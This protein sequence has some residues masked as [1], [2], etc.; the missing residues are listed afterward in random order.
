MI[1]GNISRAPAYKMD[2]FARIP[3]FQALT[4]LEMYRDVP[5]E[6]D[7]A[8]RAQAGDLMSLYDVRY[9]ITTP[10]IPG[11]YPYQDTWQRTEE[12]ALDVLPLE[13][14]AF[15]E[16][17]GYRAYR[18]VQPPIPFPFRLD[19]G[20]RGDRAVPGPGLGH[21]AGRAAIRRHRHVDLGQRPPT[22]SA[23][24]RPA[25]VRLRPVRSRPSATRAR[26]P[27]PSR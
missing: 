17:D 22:L 6:V 13:K 14:P 12:Y 19:L 20:T 7:A 3:L 26:P 16:E 4:D 1:G 27:R 11:R 8:A 15:W 25:D 10:P 18:V 24:G 9:F 2:Y 21:P 5:P 23:P